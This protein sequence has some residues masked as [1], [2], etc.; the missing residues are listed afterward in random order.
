M[1][2]DFS[3]FKSHSKT[4][5]VPDFKLIS[6]WH[7][8]C[9]ANKFEN[10][11]RISW[12]SQANRRVAINCARSFIHLQISYNLHILYIQRLHIPTYIH[13]NFSHFVGNVYQITS[14]NRA[15]ARRVT[16]PEI[17]IRTNLKIP[18]SNSAI[19]YLSPSSDIRVYLYLVFRSGGVESIAKTV[20]RAT[21]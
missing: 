13:S 11:A 6:R 20:P 16:W 15:R 1:H 19:I 2:R 21:S 5:F 7:A 4:R 8:P 10:I 14:S 9:V 3:N 12:I 17:P 18:V